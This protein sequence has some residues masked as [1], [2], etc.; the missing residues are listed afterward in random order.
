VAIIPIQG[1]LTKAESWFGAEWLQL[2]AQIGGY[3]Q[4]A[5]NDAGVRA[6]LLQVDSPGGETTGC[7]ELSDYIYS[8]RG[9]KPIYA[10]ADDFAF[11]R[12]TR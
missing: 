5:V 1:V 4:D 11:S 12:P 3:L 2:Y 6:I 8:I 10:V 7:L 9:A